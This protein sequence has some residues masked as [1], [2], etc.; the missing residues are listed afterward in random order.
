MKWFHLSAEN[1]N[2]FAQYFLGIYYSPNQDNGENDFSLANGEIH[3][4]AKI[5]KLNDND[6]DAYW[7][8]VK[9]VQW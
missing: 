3:K 6:Y 7:E 8:K 4:T 1:G 9:E 2:S 5:I